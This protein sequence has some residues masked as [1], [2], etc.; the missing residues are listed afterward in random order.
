VRINSNFGAAYNNR[1]NARAAQGDKMGA[2][3]DLEKAAAIFEQE[4]NKDLYQQVMKN[5]QELK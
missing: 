4:G 3:K 2:L 1:G 5:I